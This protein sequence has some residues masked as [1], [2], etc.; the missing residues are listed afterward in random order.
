MSAQVREVVPVAGSDVFEERVRYAADTVC[1][2]W[3]VCSL[4]RSMTE[5][6]VRLVLMADDE[7]A[8]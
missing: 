7:R 3:Q 2:V 5:S 8:K 1:A 6:G 4:Y